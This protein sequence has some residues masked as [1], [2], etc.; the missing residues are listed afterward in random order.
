MNTIAIINQKG[1]VAKTTTAHAIGAGLALKGYRVLFV[2]LDAQGNLS[3]AM[4]ATRGDYSAL[5]ILQGKAPAQKA[6][7]T[8]RYY[9]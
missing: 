3:Y 1:G 8:R 6:V 4:A 7:Q 5:D 2:D 9:P